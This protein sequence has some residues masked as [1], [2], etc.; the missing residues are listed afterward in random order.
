MALRNLSASP[1]FADSLFS[2]RFHHIDRLFRQLTEYTSV[3]AIPAYDLKKQDASHYLLTVSVPGWKEEELEIEMV[4]G[5]LNISGKHTEETTE[6]QTC[7]IH[8]GIR[9]A[10]FQLSFSLPEH[11]KVN[12]AK[13]EHGLLLVNIYQELTLVS[14]WG[15]RGSQRTCNLK[16]DGYIRAFSF[17]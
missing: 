2:N 11:T 12:N 7:W 6:D 4:G 14:D 10:D 17:L 13:L 16:Y 8:R 5:N 15:E 9:K 3:A 1:V